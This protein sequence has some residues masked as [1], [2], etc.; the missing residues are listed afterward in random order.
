MYKS[1]SADVIDKVV[2]YHK[3]HEGISRVVKIKHAHKAFLGIELSEAEHQDLCRT[4][5]SLVEQKVIEC[6]SV[7][8]ALEFLSRALGKLKTFVV[9]GTP[10]D[11]LK[12]ITDGRDISRYFTGIYGS[13]RK[14]E[15]IVNEQVER[16]GLDAKRCLFV[17][18]AMTDYNAAKACAMPFLGR[19]KPGEINPF[20]DGTDIAS[21]LTDLGQRAGIE[22]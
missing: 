2:S 5:A 16:Y 22:Y 8:G 13:P 17:G 6:N 1:H 10:E 21:D 15:D 4:Y 9:S 18:D 19:V 12:R 14:K 20:P 3:A 7:P 11:E